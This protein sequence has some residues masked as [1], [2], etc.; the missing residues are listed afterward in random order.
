[1]YKKI[2]IIEYLHYM[3]LIKQLVQFKQIV[4]YKDFKIIL[5]FYCAFESYEI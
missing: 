3:L 4:S 1:M 2:I 5:S